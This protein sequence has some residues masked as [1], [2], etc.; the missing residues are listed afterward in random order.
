MTENEIIEKLKATQ[1]ERRFNHT[2]GVMEE[3]VRLAPLLA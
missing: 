3:A 1:K 2:L